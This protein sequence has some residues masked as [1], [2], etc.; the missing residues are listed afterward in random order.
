MEEF[1]TF[2]RWSFPCGRGKLWVVNPVSNGIQA[3]TPAP[4]EIISTGLKRSL[5]YLQNN[6]FRP[7]N[8]RHLVAASG[9]SPRGLT[10]AFMRELGRGPGE[11]LRRLRLEHACQLL[12]ASQLRMDAISTACGFNSVNSFWVAFR[13]SVGITP[14]LYRRINSSALAEEKNLRQIEA[15]N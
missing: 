15:A 8:V 2:D 7:I 9:M 5:D 6:W 14:G 10:K 1:M 12:R 4:A 3:A 13:R 11:E